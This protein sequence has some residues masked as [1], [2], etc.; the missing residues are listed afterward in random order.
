MRL[1]CRTALLRGSLL[2]RAARGIHEATPF[3]NAIGYTKDIELRLLRN[4]RPVRLVARTDS[5]VGFTQWQTI[6]S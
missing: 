6:P 1:L 4:E 3:V 5:K 2:E